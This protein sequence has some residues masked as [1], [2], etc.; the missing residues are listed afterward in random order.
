MAQATQHVVGNIAAIYDLRTNVGPNNKSVI[1]FKVL[2]TPRKQVNGEWTDGIP[3]PSYVT[4]WGR[5]A[6]NIHEHWDIGDRV[7]VLGRIDMKDGYT[8]KN[9]EEVPPRPYIIAET[10]GHDNSFHASEQ[11][12]D[13]KNNSRFDSNGNV[14][15]NSNN[16]GNRS[17]RRNNSNN[18]GG[19]SGNNSGGNNRNR[20]QGQQR[21]QAAPVADEDIS[22][23]D[24]L[25]LGD[26]MDF[27]TNE[28][29]PF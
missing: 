27:G 9:G 21:Q 25:D 10:A 7:F 26:N 16:G 23:S 13:K 2:T 18:S 29:L 20:N 24:D 11:I 1:E 12:R 14:T 5:L 15:T 17:E 3:Y 28:P 19:N 22:L 4:A 6:E 8:N